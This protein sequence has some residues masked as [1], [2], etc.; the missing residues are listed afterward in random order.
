MQGKLAD[1]C[2]AGSG[3]SILGCRIRQGRSGALPD[4]LLA[5]ISCI[6]MLCML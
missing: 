5:L 3:L 4:E 6:F 2:Q 1:S